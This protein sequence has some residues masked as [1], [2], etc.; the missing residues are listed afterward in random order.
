MAG[1]DPSAAARRANRRIVILTLCFSLAAL[2]SLSA[3]AA[4]LPGPRNAAALVYGA[5]LVACSLCSCLYNVLEASPRRRLLR[6]LDHSA[7]FLLIAGTYTP[8]ASGGIGGP[9]GVALLAWV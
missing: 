2:L 1:T 9:F 6:T 7:I 8:F 4:V 3:W 5:T